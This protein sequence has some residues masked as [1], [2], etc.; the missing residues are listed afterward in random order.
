M[1]SIW[2]KL[3]RVAKDRGTLKARVAQEAG[4]FVSESRW[5]DAYERARKLEADSKSPQEKRFYRMVAR[6]VANAMWFANLQF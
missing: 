4:R 2:G 6:R 5:T 1:Q 3:L